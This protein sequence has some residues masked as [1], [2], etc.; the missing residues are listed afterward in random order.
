[1]NTIITMKANKY[2]LKPTQEQ[3]EKIAVQFGC[4]RFV[5]N[6][7]LAKKKQFWDSGAYN[8]TR[9]ELQ[10]MLVGMKKDKD[11]QWLKKAHS[12]VL[13]SSLLH[14]DTAFQNFFA[15]RAKF[16]RF[17]SKYGKQSCQYP[18]GVKIKDRLIFL[19]KVGWVKAVIHRE[20]I[21]KIKTVTISRDATGCYFA[22]VLL[23]DQS[24]KPEKIKQ[25]ETH[26]GL[27]MGIIDFVTMSNGTKIENPRF[28]NRQLKNLRRKQQQ[29]SGKKKGSA[30]HKKSKILV[31][32]LHKKVK[33]AR[34]DFQHKLSFD[35]ANKNH[36]VS[37][38]DINMRGLSKNHKL[39][40]HLL[41]L[42]WFDFTKKLQYKQDD[43]GHY[44]SKI[45]R[46]YASS[47]T[48]CDCHHKVDSLPLGVREWT[49]SSCGTVHD[50]D[51]NAAINI[52]EQGIIKIKAEGITVS[53]CGDFNVSRVTMN[54]QT[55]T[56]QEA[57]FIVHRT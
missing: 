51:E 3:R 45:D 48:C 37:I 7:G 43:R 36:V 4:A 25:I 50:R 28:V 39:A 17:K 2:K 6:D 24:V 18:Q 46:F 40:R 33:N 56:K 12:Q 22:S 31:A 15:G 35:L 1:M 55:S 57:P 10:S 54:S 30:N 34:N 9:Y 23:D 21:G 44:L 14:L 13:Q 11:T 19:P 20:A 53:A 42:G 26:I 8:I 27:D 47:K 5:F 32:K 52:D 49:C 29:L 38:E 41:D 16:P